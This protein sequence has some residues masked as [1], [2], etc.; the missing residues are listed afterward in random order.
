M[1]KVKDPAVL[2]AAVSKSKVDTRAVL[3]GGPHEITHDAQDVEGQL[4][5]RRLCRFLVTWTTCLWPAAGVNHLRV[6]YHLFRLRGHCLGVNVSL[7]L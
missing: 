1:L 6:L 5:F 4:L 2:V 3:G 7:W